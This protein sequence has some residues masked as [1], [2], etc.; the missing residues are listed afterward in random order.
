MITSFSVLCCFGND[1]PEDG[2]LYDNEEQHYHSITNDYVI[3][4]VKTVSS[5]K[6]SHLNF[7]WKLF[8][9]FP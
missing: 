1:T 8:F 3:G 6:L 5:G 7:H 4:H 9:V 2:F